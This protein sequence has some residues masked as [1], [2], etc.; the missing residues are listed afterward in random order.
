MNELTGHLFLSQERIAFDLAPSRSQESFCENNN[1][2]NT[3]ILTKSTTLLQARKV[4]ENPS[5]FYTHYL[6]LQMLERTSTQTKP[7]MFIHN[8]ADFGHEKNK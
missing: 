4:V 5:A 7:I 8:T 2:I 3:L 1:I 6:P